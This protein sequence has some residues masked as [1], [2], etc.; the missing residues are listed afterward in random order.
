[1]QPQL[2]LGARWGMS[3]AGHTSPRIFSSSGHPRPLRGALSVSV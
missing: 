1:M 2:V 3:Q